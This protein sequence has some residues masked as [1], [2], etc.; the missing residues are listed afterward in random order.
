VQIVQAFITHDHE[1]HI[2]SVLVPAKDLEQGDIELVG[3]TNGGGEILG[4]AEID[5]ANSADPADVRTNHK[6]DAKTGKLVR[7]K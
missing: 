4:I 3:A 1:G 5:I 2:T 7:K 6:L